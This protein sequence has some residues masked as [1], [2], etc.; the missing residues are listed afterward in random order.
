MH[1]LVFRG[2]TLANLGHNHVMTSKSV[3]GYVWLASSLEHSG[4]TLT[5]PVNEFIVDDNA[6]RA[7]EGADFPLNVNDDART[8]T[9]RNMLSTAVLDGEHYPVITLR[10]ASISGSMATPQITFDLT[11][12]DQTRRMSVPVV[13]DSNDRRLRA[14]GEFDIKQTDFGMKPFS[15]AMGALQ[16]LDVVKVKFELVATAT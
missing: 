11:L 16:V 2:G 15:V 14:V 1:V 3:A 6:A 9:K 12:K 8:S 5:V 7:A 13:L 10:S 4:F